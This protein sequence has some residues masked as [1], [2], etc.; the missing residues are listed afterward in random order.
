MLRMKFKKPGKQNKTKSRGILYSN[1]F[2]SIFK[3]IIELAI[4]ILVSG[5]WLL[6]IQ[7]RPCKTEIGQLYSE[8]SPVL[9]DKM[10]AN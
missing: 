8:E 4:K 5:L 2:I 3:I 1:C 10:W 7:E 9:S 6:F